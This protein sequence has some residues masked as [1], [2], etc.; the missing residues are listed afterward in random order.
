MTTALILPKKLEDL[1]AAKYERQRLT[2]WRK[3]KSPMRHI[4][5]HRR[6]GTVCVGNPLVQEGEDVNFDFF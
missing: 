2:P 5:T 3:E 1:L 4:G 6:G